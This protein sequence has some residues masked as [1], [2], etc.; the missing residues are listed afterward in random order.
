MEFIKSLNELLFP[1][2]CISCLALGLTLCSKC[3]KGW[4]PHIYRTVVGR[5]SDISL[6]VTSS[7][8]YSSIAQKVILGAKENHLS[9]A[10]EFV[11]SAITHSLEDFL[12]TEW[13]DF[14]IPIPSRKSATRLRGREFI[15]EMAK[16]ASEK[17]GI[18]ISSPLIHGRKVRDQSGL[19][20]QGRWNNLEG[21]FVVEKVDGLYG[22]AVLV[23]DL[24]TTGATL[25]EAARA[26]RYAGIQVIGAVTAALAQPL[27]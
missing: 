23:D 16:P 1:S 11:S 24:V 5:N 3:R 12:R 21:A 18:S 19:D 26:L 13:V 22:K 2:R 14:L 25:I 15:A 6:Q 8:I 9:S 20:L 4:N 27:R 17:L 7:V 10:D